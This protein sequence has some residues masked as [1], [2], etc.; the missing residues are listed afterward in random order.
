MFGS[1]VPGRRAGQLHLSCVTDSP[2][3]DK[4]LARV[5]RLTPP[6]LGIRRPK[7]LTEAVPCWRQPCFWGLLAMQALALVCFAI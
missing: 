5:A 3:P 7:A 4:P 6:R 1:T 2:S